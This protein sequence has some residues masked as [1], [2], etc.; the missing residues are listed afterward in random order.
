MPRAR[1]EKESAAVP[2]AKKIKLVD[3]F[4]AAAG[5]TSEPSAPSS[6]KKRG[7]A[8]TDRSAAVSKTLNLR[9]AVVRPCRPITMRTTTIWIGKLL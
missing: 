8:K 4:A 1:K 3:A 5:A 7:C 2:A 6:P 9:G